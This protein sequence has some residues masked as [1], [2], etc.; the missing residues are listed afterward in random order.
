VDLRSFN[1]KKNEKRRAR[2]EE[3][4]RDVSSDAAG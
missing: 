2:D 1:R 3:S 4:D